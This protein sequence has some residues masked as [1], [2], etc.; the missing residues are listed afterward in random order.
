[1]RD[2]DLMPDKVSREDSKEDSK[3]D[4]ANDLDQNY[5]SLII[6]LDIIIT[7]DNLVFYFIYTKL[8]MY[9]MMS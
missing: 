3:L 9:Y 2:K 6:E 1:M 5:L 7:K 4:L 8:I